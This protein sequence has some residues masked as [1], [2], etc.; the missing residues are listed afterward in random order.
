MYLYMFPHIAQDAPRGLQ[1][2]SKSG[3]GSKKQGKPIV[4]STFCFT[5]GCFEGARERERV[6]WGEG[7]REE[8]EWRGVS[9]RQQR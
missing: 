3:Q 2:A 9:G 5:T 4:F 8:G 6:G 1:D 7:E